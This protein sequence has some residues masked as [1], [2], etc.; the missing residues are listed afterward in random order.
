VRDLFIGSRRVLFGDC[1]SH[2]IGAQPSAS[3]ALHYVDL[4]DFKHINDTWGM[5]I[6]N[7]KRC[8]I[9]LAMRVKIHN[10]IA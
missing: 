3:L 7:P 1:A 4:D 6:R 10:S 8:S 9:G 5:S 2:W